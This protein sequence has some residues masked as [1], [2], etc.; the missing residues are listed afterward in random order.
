[1]PD[2][3]ELFEPS[4][5]LLEL[6]ARGSLTYLALMLLMRLVG[7]RESGALSITDVLVLVLIA[8]AA[9]HAVAP[10]YTSI[11][12]GAIL[13]AAILACSVAMDAVAFKFPRLARLVKASPKPLIEDGRLNWRALRRE[14]ISYDELMSQLRLHG[15]RDPG[16]VEKA[17][18]EPNGMIS[19]FRKDG[20]EPQQP[21]EPP[22]TA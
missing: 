1:M 19:V 18:L 7:Q 22:L 2:W 5:P 21:P 20:G 12:D 15:I 16:E 6:L 3:E 13:V 8:E 4:T 11:T 17:C 9:A 14:F 10:D